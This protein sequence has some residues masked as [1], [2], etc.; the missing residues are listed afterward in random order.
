[1]YCVSKN[2][3]YL[4]DS[5]RMIC[6][7]GLVVWFLLWVQEVPGS[8][9]GADHLWIYIDN[10]GKLI[11]FAGIC[12]YVHVHVYVQAGI[13]VGI[14]KPENDFDYTECYLCLWTVTTMC[15]WTLCTFIHV[16]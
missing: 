8:N 15:V 4:H 9:P 16:C 10:W 3:R 12:D 7:L 6:P 11:G 5:S 2:D 14:I 1:M 13:L